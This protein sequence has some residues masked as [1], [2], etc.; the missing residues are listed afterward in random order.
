MNATVVAVLAF[1]GILG[2]TLLGMRLRAWLPDH[3]LS[4]ETKETVRLGMGMV[5]TMTAL[6][7]GLLVASAKG[8]YDVQRTQVIQMSGKLGYLDRVLSI[9]GPET[10]EMRQLLRVSTD[11]L[12]QQLWSDRSSPEQAGAAISEAQVC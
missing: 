10:V 7:L 2:A 8:S 1:A 12:I 9:Y 3:H 5:V 6:L 11:G 4:P